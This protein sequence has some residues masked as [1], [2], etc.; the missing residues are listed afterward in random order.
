MNKFKS[1]LI[2]LLATLILVACG[3]NNDVPGKPRFT[4]MVS[5]GDSL[6][7]VGSYNVGLVAGI[8][9]GQFTI[10][11]AS[12]VKATTPTNWTEF[13][14]LSLGL[15][16]PCAAETGLDNNTAP[17]GTPLG[18]SIPV[19]QYPLCNGYAQ[20]GSRVT[21]PTGVGNK[22]VPVVPPT[23]VGFALTVPVITQIQNFLTR[24]G[25]FS[26]ND[27]VFVMAGANDVFIQASTAGAIITANPASAAV[28]TAS[29]VAAVQTAAT[30]LANDVK[31]QII[32]NG[33]KYV[34]VMNVP[35]IASTPAATPSTA[36]LLGLLV[37]SFNTQLKAN[38]PDS[39][40][41]LNVDAYTA[42][43]DE[44]ANPAKYN[45]TNVTGTACNLTYPT[46]LLGSSLACNAGNL[47]AGVLPT[48]HYLFADTVHP[49]PYGH[50]LFATYVLQAMTNKG[51]Y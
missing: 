8:G 27:I 51:W 39:I 19:T 4:A 33:A 26:A 7:D 42:S 3:G 10:N 25:S 1:G 13:T 9:G 24:H 17:P 34:V 2:L 50:L 32:G 49:T 43:K 22:N 12:S 23:P 11:A 18:T 36:G 21:D 5:F 31:T 28:A 16:M 35:D 29:G 15:G 48:D 44:V 46:N 14:S 47:N 6:S 37:T 41:V 40:N 38:L 45:L 30:E 20:G